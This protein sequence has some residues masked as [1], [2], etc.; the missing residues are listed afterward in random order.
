MTDADQSD[1]RVDDEIGAATD[2]EV[3]TASAGSMPNPPTMWCRS[4]L[5]RRAATLLTSGSRSIE[6]APP[7]SLRVATGPI[8]EAVQGAKDN[9][10][11]AP[12]NS[13]GGGRRQV[14][15]AGAE[16]EEAAEAEVVVMV[17]AAEAVA[18]TGNRARAIP[19][20]PSLRPRIPFATGHRGPVDRC[21][22]RTCRLPGI[23]DYHPGIVGR[24]HRPGRR[25][26]EHSG[27]HIDFRHAYANRG[28]RLD[29]RRRPGHAAVTSR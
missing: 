18:V 1:P 17:V 9:R 14:E 4:G 6:P 12:S 7:V 8:G 20:H 16:A 19:I 22:C 28:R 25:S 13:G 3:A 11:P 26:A 23:D 21:I 24:H 27:P 10:P 29:V 5:S 2:E 15:E